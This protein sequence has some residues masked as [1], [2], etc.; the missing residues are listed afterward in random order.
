MPGQLSCYYLW[1]HDEQIQSLDK[2]PPSGPKLPLISIHILK[3]GRPT[4]R[5]QESR[6]WHSAQEARTDSCPQ[7][8]H[9]FDHGQEAHSI[10]YSSK[11]THPG[12]GHCAE[13]D[14][15]NRQE[16]CPSTSH[17]A[18]ETTT[19]P[20]ATVPAIV[21]HKSRKRRVGRH[22]KHGICRHFGCG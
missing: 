5:H 7:S 6:P 2:P 4:H 17:C 12:P 8:S 22:I 20:H 1:R 11:E 19:H 3:N 10:D 15:Y 14:K 21:A 18:K 9:S 13:E 16:T